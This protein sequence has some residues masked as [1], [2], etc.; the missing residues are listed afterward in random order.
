VIGVCLGLQDPRRKASFTYLGLLVI[1]FLFYALI[2]LGQQLAVKFILDPEVSLYLPLLSIFMLM[3]GVLTWR[4]R[5]PPSTPFLEFL[6]HESNALFSS[7][8]RRKA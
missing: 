2:M 5:H 8:K 1:V 6:G 7:L 3:M 4:L